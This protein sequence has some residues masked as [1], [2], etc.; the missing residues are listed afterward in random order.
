[1]AAPQIPA[2]LEA[3]P[4][5]RLASYLVQFSGPV[6]TSW[7]AEVQAAGAT[8]HGYIPESAFVVR[9]TV[10][11]KEKVERLPFVRWVG[12]YHV[13]YR[14]SPSIG[15]VPSRDP[16]RAADPLRTL[17]VIVGENPAGAALAAGSFGTVTELIDNGISPG[18]VIRADP[19]R[20][21]ELAALPQVLWVEELFDTF[22]DNNTTKWV[23]QSNIFSRVPVWDQ[24]VRGQ[25]QILCVM[26]SGLDYNSCWFR[27]SLDA[28]PGP[29]HRKVIAYQT[30]GQ[31]AVYDGCNSGHGTH[32]CGTAIGDQSFINP[33]IFSGN[34]MAY[35]AKIIMQD[36]GRDNAT[37]CSAG[38]VF[39]PAN[40]AAAYQSAYDLGARVHSNSWG[41]GDNS[42]TDRCT[43][44]DNFMWSHPDFLLCFA[45]GNG[46]PDPATVHAP[47]TAK[48]CVSVGATRQ[49]PNQ[50]TIAWYSSRGPCADGRRK[51]TITAPGGD[52]NLYISSADNNIGNPPTPTCHETAYGFMGTSMAT[53][54]VAGC[55]LLVR[56][57][58]AQGF[59][60]A[61]LPGTGAAISPSG[62]LVK[63]ML[64]NSGKDM[65]AANQPN[66][67]EGWG[68]I[69]LDD[70]LYFDGDVREL[71]L[72]DET[73][74]LSTG[75]EVVYYYDV[76]SGQQPLEITLVW[77][78]YPAYPPANPA[79]A[80][81]LNL[82]VT[83]PS[84]VEYL[85]SVYSGGEST[86]GGTAD[87]LNVE[88]CV[89]RAAPEVGTWTIRVQ[90][91]NVP[92]APQPF[93]LVATGA[94]GNWPDLTGVP[95]PAGLGTRARLEPARPNPF[96]GQTTLGFALADA[97]P[98]KLEVFSVAGRRLATLVDRT[99]SA[100]TYAYEWD[101]TAAQAHGAVYFYKLTTPG[102]TITR[103][104]TLLR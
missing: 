94:F 46:G 85:G 16:D 25:G 48:N 86:T 67:D 99:L 97:G 6:E 38:S 76:D 26:D 81:N 5:D 77:T 60:P 9:M 20:I 12:P 31:G 1:L 100:G 74:G 49:S 45:N 44:V 29:T 54:A 43:Q 98:A 78:D 65:G 69:V 72:E 59:Y 90:A 27:D 53:P 95:E 37:D 23:V 102:G 83:S 41:G 96:S 22:V 56:D 32:V 52:E 66:Q 87:I 11:E 35:L 68:R 40:L 24:G 71:R 21:T 15:T 14:I 93:A 103:K 62:A 89:R 61:G 64:V 88:E 33:G 28:P 4:S 36:V 8:I 10:R 79:L 55:A 51:P 104:M 47:G 80:N 19:A 73:T 92:H 70:V 63:A 13:A 57:Y 91:P 7:K 101:A 39:V 34:G 58:L 50:E 30:Y 75:E 3:T 17:R 2:N 18:F 42:Y 82:V 84:S